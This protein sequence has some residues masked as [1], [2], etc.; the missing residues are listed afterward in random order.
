MATVQRTWFSLWVV[1]PEAV[2]IVRPLEILTVAPDLNPEPETTA[3]IVLPRSA[4]A[5]EMP[6]TVG[7][8]TMSV[9]SVTMVCRPV[10]STTGLRVIPGATADIPVSRPADIGETPEMVAAGAAVA[11][12]ARA[13]TMHTAVNSL[14]HGLIGRS[15]PWESVE[16]SQRPVDGASTEPLMDCDIEC[17]YYDNI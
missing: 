2:N 5:G 10:G 1:A 3:V 17:I 15:S 11:T 7:G 4:D 6:V 16:R 9:L 13:S 8:R 14:F 12:A